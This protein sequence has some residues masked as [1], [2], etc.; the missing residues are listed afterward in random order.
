MKMTCQVV[1]FV[2]ILLSLHTFT[3]NNC[4]QQPYTD[5]TKKVVFRLRGGV[6]LS[7]IITKLMIT[8]QFH[9]ETIPGQKTEKNLQSYHALNVIKSSIVSFQK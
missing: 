8:N 5:Y 4:H 7:K 1:T 9:G 6:W 3:Q 2:F